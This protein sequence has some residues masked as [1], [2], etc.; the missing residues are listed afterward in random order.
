MHLELGV[1]FH[2]FKDLLRVD[3]DFVTAGDKCV[4]LVVDSVT[5]PLFRCLQEGEGQVVVT[6]GVRL[7]Q[8]KRL[9]INKRMLEISLCAKVNSPDIDRHRVPQ[10]I[11]RTY[12]GHFVEPKISA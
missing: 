1:A 6:N 2:E 3:V 7:L 12:N 8:E 5:A 9:K 10:I 4:L 11:D